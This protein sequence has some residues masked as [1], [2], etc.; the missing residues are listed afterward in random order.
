MYFLE[1]VNTRDTVN[2]STCLFWLMQLMNNALSQSFYW[3]QSIFK[4]FHLHFCV[5]VLKA[6]LVFLS[7][8]LCL[9]TDSDWKDPD[10]VLMWVKCVF[11]SRPTISGWRR[12]RAARI[13]YIPPPC[14]TVISSEKNKSQP[15][16]IWG[17][18]LWDELNVVCLMWYTDGSSH[19]L[20]N[21]CICSQSVPTRNESSI[22]TS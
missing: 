5:C 9:Y 10:L 8:W 6:F 12:A 18:P 13:S 3:R 22:K 20:R 1:T 11:V 2:L 4:F 14:S 15:G 21:N 17:P 7:F 16:Q 19:G